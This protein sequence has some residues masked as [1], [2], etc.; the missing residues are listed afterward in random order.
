[1]SKL[2]KTKL[3]SV[4]A[5]NIDPIYVLFNESDDVSFDPYYNFT[6]HVSKCMC[7]KCNNMMD[8][9][10][11][12]NATNRMPEGER[13][14]MCFGNSTVLDVTCPDC[15]NTG[16]YMPLLKNGNSKKAGHVPGA[17]SVPSV[18]QGRY[19][20]KNTD[21]TGKTVS[22]EDNLVGTSKII[23]PSGKVFK[24]MTEISEVTDVEK[25]TIKVVRTEV[26]GDKRRVLPDKSGNKATSNM[27]IFAYKPDTFSTTPHKNTFVG[28]ILGTINGDVQYATSP[29]P[30]MEKFIPGAIGS[31]CKTD[32]NGRIFSP[33]FRKIDI[34]D[35]NEGC[36][37]INLRK[38]K[39]L[40][41]QFAFSKDNS[42]T[43]ATR[44]FLSEIHPDS[45]ED[46]TDLSYK[47]V[48]IAV[49][50]MSRYPMA[51][52]YAKVLADADFENRRFATLRKEQDKYVANK[53]QEMKSSLG[54]DLTDDEVKTL[55]EESKSAKTIDD[56]VL[57]ESVR[58][59]CFREHFDKIAMQ[60]KNVD[61]KILKT[62]QKSKTFDE[63][64]SSMQFFA[65]GE[66]NVKKL[67]GA[68]VKPSTIK[69]GAI[70]GEAFA[71]S[72]NFVSKFNDNM[73]GIANTMYTARK[74]GFSDPNVLKSLVD[75]TYADNVSPII[76]VCK[77][78]QPVRNVDTMRFARAL[79][80]AN[81]T[82][83]S[84]RRG[85]KVM[86]DET[87]V[88]N[89]IFGSDADRNRGYMVDGSIRAFYESVPMYKTCVDKGYII[90][91]KEEFEA[92]KRVCEEDNLLSY[93][94]NHS[95]E[96]AYI[97]YI[98][99]YGDSTKDTI[100]SM[101]EDLHVRHENGEDM[102][103]FKKIP[104]WPTDKKPLLKGRSSMREIHDQLSNM[105][106]KIPQN[107]V[108]LDYAPYEKE[109][110]HTYE[111]NG[112]HYSFKLHES[113][114][115][116]VRTSSVLD[117]CLSS[118]TDSA[119]SKS[120]IYMYM[121]DS[122]THERINCISLCRN[123]FGESKFRVDEFQ[124]A[125][126]HAVYP[127]YVDVCMKW[128]N[129]CNIDYANNRDVSA[130]GKDKFIYG[131]NGGVHM[132]HAVDD[133]SGNVLDNREMARVQKSRE[134]KAALLYGKNE[135]GSINV[136]KYDGPTIDFV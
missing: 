57:P 129:D 88:M 3:D 41:K 133:V 135:D 11:D 62:I 87:K 37:R 92:N 2:S 100:D 99:M 111:D 80:K 82:V 103:A 19:L 113:T 56:I 63:F 10:L 76:S 128:L 97:D 28:D 47:K 61:E 68:G 33:N 50:M 130:F 96:D 59:K 127:E 60:L 109:L 16:V 122:D 18:L 32:D 17:W 74:M 89:L 106:R 20:F 93:L 30:T 126:D 85:D 136:P 121:E 8:V 9:D 21:E 83:V 86:R 52:E 81:E 98:D 132:G 43:G 13:P 53:S 51:F 134:E 84:T 67:D 77:T 38:A 4:V 73:I 78:L 48:V 40:E 108:V 66:E 112:K 101:I 7:A 72:K 105:S 26:M 107:D 69:Q 6:T 36:D 114:H 35:W 64:K 46:N 31:Y 27:N 95:V 42:F 49:E 58:G 39:E 118:K 70:K 25:H 90:E 34:I 110:E 24:Y 104:V 115:D 119:V 91:S 79:Q 71:A 23:Y 117:N 45:T 75:M 55:V 54:R 131:G 15:G 12:V 123:Y 14:V 116:M 125:N 102:S 29:I 5:K 44:L 22:L 65:F 94:K 120:E 1:M 124:G